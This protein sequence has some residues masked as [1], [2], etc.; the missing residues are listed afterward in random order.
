[1]LQMRHA[2]GFFSRRRFS[3]AFLK[4]G[5]LEHLDTR[6]V[7]LGSESSGNRSRVLIWGIFK[8]KPL[9]P[10]LSPQVGREGEPSEYLY[11]QIRSSADLE[12]SAVGCLNTRCDR[13]RANS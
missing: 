3:A 1:M 5:H 2:R 12:I 4:P 13:F 8:S 11:L 10:S 6:L 7:E 9:S